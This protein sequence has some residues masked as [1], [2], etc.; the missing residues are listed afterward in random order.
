MGNTTD[1]LS[2]L[3]HYR[4]DHLI[5]K[6]AYA[7]VVIQPAG[8]NEMLK[9][10][11]PFLPLRDASIMKSI[12]GFNSNDFAHTAWPKIVFFAKCY[13][14][15]YQRMKY[16]AENM[17]LKKLVQLFMIRREVEYAH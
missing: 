9:A 7:D 5:E 10:K 17:S 11:I 6:V 14:H 1:M 13:N 3:Q 4:P 12:A 2:H 15:L 8:V 16:Q